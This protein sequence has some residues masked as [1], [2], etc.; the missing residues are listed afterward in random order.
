MIKKR[1]LAIC[2]VAA[3]AF[4][5]IGCSKEEVVSFE[6]NNTKGGGVTKETDEIEETKEMEAGDLHMLAHDGNGRTTTEEGMYRLV[7][8]EIQGQTCYVMYYVDFASKQEIVLCNDASCKHDS[9]K[10]MGVFDGSDISIALQQHPFVY[11][12]KLYVFEQDDPSGSVYSGTLS[13]QADNGGIVSENAK[14]IQM[15]LDGTERK[16]VYTF[17]EDMILGDQVIGGKDALYFI[18]KEVTKTKNDDGYTV[19]KGGKQRIRKLDI[20][21]WKLGEGIELDKE[22]QVVDAIGTK[23]LC[24]R[25][26]YPGGENPDEERNMDFEEW[27][28]MYNNT[29]EIFEAIS[30]ETGTVE[31]LAEVSNKNLNSVLVWNGRI[32]L[33]GEDA[34]VQAIDV[35]SKQVEQVPFPGQFGVTFVEAYSDRI[36]CWN[37]DDSDEKGYFWNPETGELNERSMKQK[38][39]KLNMDIL[40]ENKDGY[41]LLYDIDGEEA[42][43]GSYDV[44][45]NKYGWISKEDMYAGSY[46]ITPIKMV[47]KGFDFFEE[48]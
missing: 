26:S 23:L 36:Y 45:K 48:E 20:K 30:M 15:N 7:M 10:C 6:E 18:T 38:S 8:K 19:M 22:A 37:V 33:A 2:I 5:M 16:C 3:L 11:N 29:S 12:G 28:T 31:K 27:R 42:S 32:Y 41:L 9:T 43:D 1:L 25:T 47:S 46:D 44:K 24:R 21:E 35:E 14:L 40:A 17:P 34:S 4:G 13:E 39:A